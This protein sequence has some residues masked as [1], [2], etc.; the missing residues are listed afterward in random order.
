MGKI[1][2]AF[3]FAKL[4]LRAVAAGVLGRPKPC[5]IRSVSDVET[6]ADVIRHRL[7]FLDDFK[8][9]GEEFDIHLL[10]PRRKDLRHMRGITTHLCSKRLPAGSFWDL[11]DDVYV[12]TP[13][14]CFLEAAMRGLEQEQLLTYGMELCGTYSLAL[15]SE[16]GFVNGRQLTYAKRLQG[17][18]RK[19][20][21]VRG[22]A[23]ARRA[24]AAIADGS[25][26]PRE[27][28]TCLALSLST[29]H[30]GYGLPRPLMGE[31][32]V[33]NDI[34][35]DLCDQDYYLA[36]M[37]WPGRKLVVEY[38]GSHH[39][40]PGR[41]AKDKRRRSELAALGYSVIIVGREEAD[42]RRLFDQKAAQVSHLLGLRRRKPTPAHAMG[43]KMR[44][45]SLFQPQK[46]EE[47]CAHAQLP[48]L[49]A[50]LRVRRERVDGRWD[51]IA[52]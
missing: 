50:G 31:P 34:E 42:S 14:R 35:R 16:D 33:P 23:R 7:S 48:L 13:E 45:K 9:D 27:T 44:Q 10:V 15:G 36:D 5:G 25:D 20:K 52:T 3:P 30:G 22:I 6:R 21:S 1:F 2:I 19:Y 32:I 47:P 51:A 41:A 38:D 49:P 17:Y 46:G 43:R 4:C 28:A 37:C 18:L 39:D 29:W 40:E 8:L 11:G 24:A 12:V 26:S